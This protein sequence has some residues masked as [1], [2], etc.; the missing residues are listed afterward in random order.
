MT[1]EEIKQ[2]V[3]NVLDEINQELPQEK[4]LEKSETTVLF[5]K[6]GQ[7]DSLGLVNLIVAIEEKLQEEC[8]VSITL[9]DER[10]M[11]QRNS[12]FR[13]VASLIDY[14]AMLLNEEID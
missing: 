10:A 3:F 7:L 2:A 14:I 1:R 13:T 6:F 8:N 12:P 9:A 5:G 11:S 4:Q